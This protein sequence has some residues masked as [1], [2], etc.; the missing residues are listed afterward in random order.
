[1]NISKQTERFEKQYG[2]VEL[3]KVAISTIN[4]IMV[5]ANICSKKILQDIFLEELESMEKIL[6]SKKIVK[7]KE[8]YD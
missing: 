6:N 4:K 5:N 8:I 3:L 1:M 2:S 7:N